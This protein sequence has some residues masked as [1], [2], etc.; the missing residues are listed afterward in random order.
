[1]K[2]SV[3]KLLIRITLAMSLSNASGPFSWIYFSAAVRISSG[4]LNMSFFLGTY[5]SLTCGFL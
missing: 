4:L 5:H 2:L 3:N 1:M